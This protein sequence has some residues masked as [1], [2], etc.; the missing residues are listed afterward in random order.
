MRWRIDI[1]P[2]PLVQAAGIAIRLTRWWAAY[3]ITF[4]IVIVAALL[5]T[6]VVPPLQTSGIGLVSTLAA[7]LLHGVVLLL[8]FAWI[9]WYEQRPVRSVG[10]VGRMQKAQMLKGFGIGAGVFALAT[11]VLAI[12]GAVHLTPTESGPV[13][14]DALL[15]AL[16]MVP[17][18][19]F[20]AAAQEALSR[21][22]LLQ[23][24]GLQL[25]AWTAII[26]QSVLWAIVRAASAGT[27]DLM[28][29][30]NLVCIGV[31][32]AFVAL[33]WGSLWLALGL[34]AGWS[35]FATSVLGILTVGGPE[36][37]SIL[38]VVPTSASWLS[39]GQ[40]GIVASPV[41]TVAVALGGIVAY[42]RL[43]E[44]PGIPLPAPPPPTYD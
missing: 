44:Q 6:P 27:T 22:F 31:V 8:L 34:Q 19:L 10:F 14:I 23:V 16:I 5:I 7:V 43:L 25:A 42:R 21:G 29:L 26:G 18:W 36:P 28:A 12:V 37:Q 4:G 32:L 24:T 40:A 39:G 15:P 11:V 33:R 41:V 9:K 35:W 13:R 2:A 20:M 3:L 38:S 17:L 1:V 30:L